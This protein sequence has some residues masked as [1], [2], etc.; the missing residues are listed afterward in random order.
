MI[1][2]SRVYIPECKTHTQLYIL[3]A[4][5]STI[6]EPVPNP[7]LLI[8]TYYLLNFIFCLR[9]SGPIEA[10]N[11]AAR[12]SL[13]PTAA[14]PLHSSQVA[15]LSFR[16]HSSHMVHLLLLLFVPVPSPAILKFHLCLTC[17]SNWLLASFFTI[18]SE[19]GAAFQKQSFL[20][21]II[22]NRIQVSTHHSITKI[23][24]LSSFLNSYQG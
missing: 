11:W 7:M 16:P 21:N 19:L 15:H 24:L 14:M 18:Q 3:G 4:L 22:S 10:S 5:I 23:S 8:L 17:L 13:L 6:A 20:G 1:P 9:C 2:A 12:S